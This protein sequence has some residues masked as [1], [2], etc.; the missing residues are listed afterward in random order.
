MAVPLKCE[1]QEDVTGAAS[2]TT[3]KRRQAEEN[4]GDMDWK[5]ESEGW[6]DFHRAGHEFARNFAG[7]PCNLS[8]GF[9]ILTRF[10]AC[11]RS[12]AGRASDL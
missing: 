10:E 3:T 9:A 1:V 2:C 4:K 12:S 11:W 7:A 6:E 5:Q 8:T